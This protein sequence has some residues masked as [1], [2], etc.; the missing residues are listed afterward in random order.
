MVLVAPNSKLILPSQDKIQNLCKI[1]VIENF[2][3]VSIESLNINKQ[4]MP[5]EP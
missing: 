3:C 1:Q 5:P 2:A 4:K